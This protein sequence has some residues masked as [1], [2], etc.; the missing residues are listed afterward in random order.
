MLNS[1]II[2]IINKLNKLN[3]MSARARYEIEI[4]HNHEV[5][6]LV[7]LFCTTQLFKDHKNYKYPQDYFFKEF[8]K[9][10]AKYYRFSGDDNV[11]FDTVRK[12]AAGEANICGG[13]GKMTG[14][15][16]RY[17]KN[18]Y[19]TTEESHEQKIDEFAKKYGISFIPTKDV[20]LFIGVTEI[21]NKL[22]RID[23]ILAASKWADIRERSYDDETFTAPLPKKME[24]GLVPLCIRNKAVQKYTNLRS[25]YTSLRQTNIDEDEDEEEPE[26]IRA[27]TI[28]VIPA[29]DD[30]DW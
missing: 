18:R 29:F 4:F 17:F 7:A 19:K 25:S 28:I 8:R 2:N 11:Y 22:D 3:K 26:K 21:W 5:Q 20:R 23:D 6:G 12:E 10:A 13:S 1:R 30:D 14:S 9:F 15:A 24:K 27:P 16:A